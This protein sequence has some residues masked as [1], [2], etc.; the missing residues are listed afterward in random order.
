MK[1]EDIRAR[2]EAMSLSLT[3]LAGELGVDRQTVWRWEDGR[4]KPPPFL[5]DALKRVEERV[6]R[7]KGRGGE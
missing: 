1:A 2:R 5:E 4:H 7:R 6:R 3:D